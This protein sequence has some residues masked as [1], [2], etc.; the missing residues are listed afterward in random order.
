M[1]RGVDGRS[2][3]DRKRD[4]R[5]VQ[6]RQVRVARAQAMGRLI[7]EVARGAMRLADPAVPVEEAAATFATLF[8]ATLP[9]AR[10]GPALVERIGLDRARAIVDVGLREE[11]SAALLALAA[12]VALVSGDADAAAAHAMRAREVVDDPQL[13][14][15]VAIARER[16]GR[17]VD[18][19][20]ELRDVL[21]GDPGLASGQLLRGE[22]LRLAAAWEAT[23]GD[24]AADLLA[25]FRDRG[26]LD[27]LASAVEDLLAR[28][29]E[30]RRRVDHL[31][32]ECPASGDAPGIARDRAWTMAVDD[33]A[34]VLTELA[35]DPEVPPDVARRAAE[36]A[37][38]ATWGLW[39]V[40]ELAEPDAVVTE[41]L[42]GARL[43]V[44]LARDQRDGLQPGSVLMGCL[45]AVDGVW[46]SWGGFVWVSPEVAT[47]AARGVVWFIEQICRQQGA[48]HGPMA[49]WV[50]RV[51][52]EIERCDWPPEPVLPAPQ[53]IVGTISSTVATIMPELVRLNLDLA[54]EVAASVPRSS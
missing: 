52:R 25:E 17:V 23:P 37:E 10:L 13:G 39:H 20:R 16:Q 12:D 1:P 51:G 6:R 42:T 5:R 11:P 34:T 21:R 31:L 45:G 38:C 24:A 35:D 22:L 3:K 53:V 43:S 46:R 15:R 27:A 54:T 19:L 9:S 48:F 41:L 50:R 49:D 8:A 36:W 26:P 33:E 32:G 30:L 29:P 47:G 4:K 2:K 18:A 44:H 28:R 7:D 40:D 14:M